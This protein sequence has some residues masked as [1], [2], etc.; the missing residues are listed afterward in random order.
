MNYYIE[1]RMLSFQNPF[2]QSI[3]TQH[4][5]EALFNFKVKVMTKYHSD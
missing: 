2:G 5:H 4:P 3:K 1:I